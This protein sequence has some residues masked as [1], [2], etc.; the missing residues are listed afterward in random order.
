MVEMTTLIVAAIN[1]ATAGAP[2]PLALACAVR[3]D[4]ESVYFAVSL[5]KED[6]Y[7][8]PA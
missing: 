5:R 7:R 8:M 3:I 1:G 2:L 6:W 4:D